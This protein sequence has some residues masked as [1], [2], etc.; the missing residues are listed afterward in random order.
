MMFCSA[1]DRNLSRG[2]KR[3]QA[4]ASEDGCQR[5]G[6]PRKWGAEERPLRTGG[7]PREAGRR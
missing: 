7:A 5:P 3:A 4:E 2:R 6:D 1:S